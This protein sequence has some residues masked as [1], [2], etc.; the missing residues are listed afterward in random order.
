MFRIDSPTLALWKSENVRSVVVRFVSGGCAGTKLSVERT[1]E[2]PAGFESFDL[3]G[4][5]AH[6][7]PSDRERLEG[8]RITRVEKGAKEV[9]MYVAPKVLGRCGCGSSFSFS[10]FEKASSAHSD[11]KGRSPSETGIDPAKLSALKARF[12]RGA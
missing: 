4:T 11:A 8:A 1:D 2:I 7:D 6:F 3:G 10:P 5:V 12:A 9:W